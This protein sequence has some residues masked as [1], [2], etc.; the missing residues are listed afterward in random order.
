[1]N[2]ETSPCD[3]CTCV[4]GDAGFYRWQFLGEPV[5]LDD[6]GNPTDVSRTCPRKMVTEDSCY[7]L[8][9]Y[10]HYKAGHLLKAGGVSE[11]PYLYMEAMRVIDGAI[12]QARKN[13]V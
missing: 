5:F 12:A 6:D 9:L 1:M 4:D 7:L 13:G 2:P 11:Q 8:S 3:T 10:S